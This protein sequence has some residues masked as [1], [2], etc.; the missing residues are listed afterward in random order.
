[1]ATSGT[2]V[3]NFGD[4][5][6]PTQGNGNV[7]GTVFNDLNGNGT[8]DPGEPGI[9]GVTVTLKDPSGNPVG[10]TTTDASGNYSFPNVP[11]GPR[12]ETSTTGGD[13]AEPTWP[14]SRRGRDGVRGHQ[15]MLKDRRQRT[16][17]TSS[18]T[19]PG[20]YVVETRL[21]ST[22]PQAGTPAWRT[23]ATNVTCSTT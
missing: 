2:A 11:P 14:R 13:A 5:K 3:A 21:V 23:S 6:A 7:T 18:R 16:A 20:P 10:T 17:T 4:Q 12:V 8:Q 1:M 19:T 22:T 15:P 9:P